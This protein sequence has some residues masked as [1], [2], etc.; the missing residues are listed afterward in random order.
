MKGKRGHGAYFRK[1]WNANGGFLADSDAVV[2][3]RSSVLLSPLFWQTPG[4]VLNPDFSITTFSLEFLSQNPQRS[5]ISSWSWHI[6]S[7]LESKTPSLVVL[8]LSL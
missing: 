4:S 2:A 8:A 6:Q 7:Y 5:E 3:S 1:G